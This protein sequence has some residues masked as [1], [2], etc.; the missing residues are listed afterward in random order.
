MDGSGGG[1]SVRA[2]LA[3]GAIRDKASSEVTIP[4]DLRPPELDRVANEEGR[5]A[6]VAVINARVEKT[7]GVTRLIGANDGEAWTM[8]RL[9]RT[10]IPFVAKLTKR[11]REKPAGTDTPQPFRSAAREPDERKTVNSRLRLVVAPTFQEIDPRRESVRLAR[12]AE[13]KAVLRETVMPLLCSRWNEME[14]NDGAKDNRRWK[15]RVNRGR[16]AYATR[17]TNFA[18]NTFRQRPGEIYSI[19]YRAVD[20]GFRLASVRNVRSANISDPRDIEI[21]IE[22]MDARV[23]PSYAVREA[24]ETE[25]KGL[26]KRCSRILGN[27]VTSGNCLGEQPPVTLYSPDTK[28]RNRPET[29]P[30]G[31]KIINREFLE[32]TSLLGTDSANDLLSYYVILIQNREIGRKILAIQFQ[33]MTCFQEFFGQY[34]CSLAAKFSADFSRYEGPTGPCKPDRHSVPLPHGV[35]LNHP[36]L[37]DRRHYARPA[38]GPCPS[39]VRPGCR[40]P[41]S[42]PEET[43]TRGPPWNPMHDEIDS[44]WKWVSE[45]SRATR[46]AACPEDSVREENG[47]CKCKGVTYCP[48]VDCEADLSASLIKPG[49]HKTPGNCCDHFVCLP[50]DAPRPEPCPEDSVWTEDGKCECAPCPPASCQPGHRPVQV[51]PALDP[52]VPD[53]CCPLYEC[54]PA[55]A[56]SWVKVA[57]EMSKSAKYCIYE[58]KARKLGERWQESDCVSCICQEDG[59][60]CQEPMCKS[61]ENAIPPDPGECCPHCPPLENTTLHEPRPPC[62]TSLEDCELTCEHG[63]ARDEN[64]CPICGVRATTEIG[65]VDEANCPELPHCGFNCDIKKNEKG[66]SVCSCETLETFEQQ[67]INDT[68]S[69]DDTGKKVC[70]EVKC[71]LHCER[72]LVMDENDCTFC[73][74]REPGSG[75]PPL[76]GCRKRCAFGYR[77]NKRGCSICRCRASCTDH[78]NDTYPEGSTWHP[79]WCTSCTCETGGKLSCKETVCSVACNDPLPPQPETCC[80]VC[81]ITVPTK[82]NGPVSG[83]HQGGKG[84]GTVPITLIAILALLCVLLIV[85]IVRGRF[86]ARLSPSEASYSTYP[87]QYYK[88]VPAYDTPVHRNEKIVPL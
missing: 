53:R 7:S 12:Q 5:C 59:V 34:F 22:T 20:L 13:R 76:V 64:D 47:A 9:S 31:G 80:P 14:R 69:V 85:H 38:A 49:D 87:P 55:E 74:C 51:K 72:G 77:T 81:P 6:L 43:E 25:D 60:S 56:V 10:R 50:P 19:P 70:P 8:T 52:E 35:E 63:Y 71:D 45:T 33:E 66:C 61:C 46:G 4:M 15:T 68:V 11:R 26:Q 36:K 83:H 27:D 3:R 17:V 28:S 79:N 29:F 44:G 16:K 39:R 2:T 40:T 58:N 21:A 57:T 62:P 48:I 23:A 73:K 67:P 75:C 78:L 41:A 32:V 54:R 1:P 42:S 30:Q 86:R 65:S 24:T 18:T 82:G 84:W 88:C 37:S